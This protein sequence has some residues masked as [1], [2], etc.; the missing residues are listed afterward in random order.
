MR[1]G[2]ISELK[3]ADPKT[4][5]EL[6]RE[7]VYGYRMLGRAGLGRGL[8]AHLTARM[9]GTETFWTYQ[10]G[11]SVEEVAIDVLCEADFEVTPL[12]GVSRPNPSIRAHGMI[13]E[14]REDVNC[15]VH[16]H[17]NAAVAMGAIGQNLVS[18]D[19]NSARWGGEIAIMKDFDDVHEIAQQGPLMLEAMGQGK[20]IIVK[21]HGV[22]VAAKNIREAIVR[23]L[24]LEQSMIVQLTAQAAGTLNTMP[25]G[26][27]EDAKGF[28]NSDAYFDGSWN[29]LK[30]ALAREGGDVNLETFIDPSEV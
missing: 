6:K 13:Y 28:L 25:E 2:K 15:I 3:A 22:F 23:A 16:H 14:H 24:E 26:E 17:S 5:D 9:P 7:L 10:I 1:I 8:L 11:Y 20:A 30:R 19:R 12:D 4:V 21:H 27:I 18:Y 29:Y